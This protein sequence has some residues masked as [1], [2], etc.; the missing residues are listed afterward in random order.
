MKTSPSWL[1]AVLFCVLAIP[2]CL[3]AQVA[4]PRFTNVTV[5]PDGRASLQL[6]VQPG[7][8]YTVE[9][10]EDLK[11]W[12]YAFTARS[13][14]NVFPIVSPGPA[15][16]MGTIFLRALVGHKLYAEGEFQFTVA[17]RSFGGLP[18][19]PITYPVLI[20]YEA[21]VFVFEN[22]AP[23]PLR[24]AVFITGPPGSGVTNFMS[25]HANIGTERAS[26]STWGGGPGASPVMAGEWTVNYKGSNVSFAMP[27][28][29]VAE[30]F[31]LPVPTV[32]VSNGMLTALTWEF[33]NP[34]T[35]Q[36]A[37]NP[38][39]RIKRIDV[40]IRNTGGVELV[41]DSHEPAERSHTFSPAI[42]WSSVGVV[43]LA[44]KD[45]LGSRY[46]VSYAR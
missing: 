23:Y 16:Q 35:G 42:P 12:D 1:V 33:R 13:E 37:A 22:D 32:T 3:P 8:E 11:S 27:A 39:G 6:L 43:Q 40:E 24:E 36:L 9:A 28:P 20:W 38:S 34:S 21:V 29:Q 15:S 19:P 14:S 46:A 44:Y 18:Q 17:Q 45:N 4:A 41:D 25:A 31:M 7:Q 2:V 30:Q 5:L 10:S 26:Y